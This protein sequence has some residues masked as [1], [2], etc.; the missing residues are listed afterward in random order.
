MLVAAP[1]RS[2]GS[3]G[4][5]TCRRLMR[6]IVESS[7]VE[8]RPTAVPWS[9]DGHEISARSNDRRGGFGTVDRVHQKM[10]YCRWRSSSAAICPPAGLLP[11]ARQTRI[12]D[13]A[14]AEAWSPRV[15]AAAATTSICDAVSHHDTSRRHLA[16]TL[17]ERLEVPTRTKSEVEQRNQGRD[18]A[19][20]RSRTSYRDSES[21]PTCARLPTASSSRICGIGARRRERKSSDRPRRNRE[22]DG[23][24]GHASVHVAGNSAAA[25]SPTR[26]TTLPLGVIWY[27]C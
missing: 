11:G 16:S 27:K 25:R 15:A 13:Q 21:R 4:T 26:G 8:C 2:A 20:L 18:W 19:S 3:R 14:G 22:T 12:A 23:R 10:R 6:R 24:R 1:L 5:H 9:I 7:S 17:A